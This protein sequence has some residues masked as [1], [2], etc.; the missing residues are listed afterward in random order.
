MISPVHHHLKSQLAT[1]QSS[2]GFQT[3]MFRRCLSPLCILILILICM[4][5]T[6]SSSPLGHRGALSFSNS[7]RLTRTIRAGVQKLLSR[8]KQ[9][10]FGD[11]LFEYRELMLSSLPAVTVSYQSWLHM[12]DT[13]RLRLASHN[14]QTFWTHLEV[15]RQQLERERDA[16]N[17]RRE[18]RRGKRGKPQS[19]LRQ[20]FVSLQIDLRDLMK[21]VNSQLNSL[22]ITASTKSPLLHPL[23]ATSS[24]GPIPSMHHSTESNTVHQ[25]PT[26]TDNPRSSAHSSTQSSTSMMEKTSV[27][28]PQPTLASAGF[29]FTG[30]SV[31][32]QQTTTAETSSW[33]QHLRGYVILR[34]LERYLSR[35]ARDYAVLQAK[36]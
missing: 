35:L 6:N 15:Q 22:S 10:V 36:Y 14:L 17:E 34:D 4:V 28:L 23:H 19:T 2:A 7:L 1:E 3:E 20:S 25:T 29:I 27:S 11:E 24:S 18:Q 32:T 31:D 26:R 13:E 16:T 33:I 5:S 9:Q 30:G 8:Y 12:Q 21:Q